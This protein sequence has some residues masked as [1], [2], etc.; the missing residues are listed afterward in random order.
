MLGVEP[1]QFPSVDAGRP[2]GVEPVP[3]GQQHRVVAGRLKPK[4]QGDRRKGMAGIRP[5]NHGDMHRVT[6]SHQ[7]LGTAG[8]AHWA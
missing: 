2:G 5:G 7:H 4:A 8:Q 6:L 3:A 1:E